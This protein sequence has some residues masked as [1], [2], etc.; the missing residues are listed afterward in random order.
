M[1]I[2][3]QRHLAN[4]A[5]AAATAGLL[6]A[7]LFKP[8]LGYWRPIAA[9]LLASTTPTGA[10][11]TTNVNSDLGPLI[12]GITQQLQ[13]G[14]K[15]NKLYTT[16]DSVPPLVAMQV[17]ISDDQELAGKFLKPYD[18]GN[19][20]M[21]VYLFYS[22][23][24]T[25]EMLELYEKA[26][27]LIHEYQMPIGGMLGGNIEGEMTWQCEARVDKM[28][29]S[30]RHF[31]RAFVSSATAALV[32]LLAHRYLPS[33]KRLLQLTS[34]AAIA[35]HAATLASIQ[36]LL[37]SQFVH[38]VEEILKLNNIEKQLS[39]MPSCQL[40][41]VGNNE[42]RVQMIYTN[43]KQLDGQCLFL[44]N[45]EIPQTGG[46]YLNYD[47]LASVEMR[48]FVG[49]VKEKIAAKGIPIVGELSGQVLVQEEQRRFLSPVWEVMRDLC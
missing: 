10:H 35:A 3:P 17:I 11:L 4:T 33:S 26:V 41:V 15:S 24:D 14:V 18:F 43:K 42:Y 25:P 7:Y 29:A 20:E 39:T 31:A 48:Y 16:G 2:E 13:A 45:S 6:S 8:T 46:I 38:E 37:P 12:E 28:T 21:R 9:T 22:P 34:G 1:R 19:K 27:A 23:L 5:V 40:Y 32:S 36:P 30:P 47:P 44:N 49:Q